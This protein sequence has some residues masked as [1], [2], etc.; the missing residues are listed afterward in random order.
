M[1]RPIADYR[2]VR[3]SRRRTMCLRIHP[4]NRIEVLAPH[5]A[6][7][8]EIADFVA[9]KQRW[10]EIKLHFNR[11][12]RTPYQPKRFEDGE[13]FRLLGRDYRLDRS[14]SSGVEIRGDMLCVAAASA[15]Q[16]WMLITQWYQTQALAHFRQRT[17]TWAQR[18]GVRPQL[19]GVKSYRSRWGSCHADG[20]IYFNWRLVMA[21]E[22]V[23][24]YVVVHEL[25]HLR[26]AN[27][28]RQ[29]WHL[30]GQNLPE[31]DQA[32]QWLKVHG[33]SLN[34]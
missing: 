26:H 10:I 31:F 8:G 21:P 3:S 14:G 16:A 30:V 20:R 32:R 33:L 7:A 19:I 34:L 13:M 11:H 22:F 5:W 9:S 6:A 27:H 29:F 15:S 2:I 23:T 18:I 17:E 4:D 28:S 12:V 1:S 24:D 25:C